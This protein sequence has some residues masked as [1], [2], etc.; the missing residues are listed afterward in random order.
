MHVRQHVVLDAADLKRLTA[1]K[2]LTLT[3]DTTV[4]DL[5]LSPVEYERARPLGHRPRDLVNHAPPATTL[6]R[7]RGDCPYCERKD[8]LIGA[9]VKNKHKG[10]PIPWLGPGGVACPVCKR[11]FPSERSL[12]IH[13]IV[14]AKKRGQPKTPTPAGPKRGPG[15]PS[16]STTKKPTPSEGGKA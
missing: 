4:I 6:L 2:T 11:K 10:K 7:Q 12:G 15:R 5:S 13:S 16:G 9:H 1:F 14:H 8:V 3:L